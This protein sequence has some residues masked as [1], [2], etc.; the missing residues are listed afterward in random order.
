MSS[1][2]NSDQASAIFSSSG[3][4]KKLDLEENFFPCY[5]IDRKDEKD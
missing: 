1:L 2:Y 4:S 5:C 3:L